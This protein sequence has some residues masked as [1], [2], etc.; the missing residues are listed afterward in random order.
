MTVK[1]SPLLIARL[2]SSSDKA[3]REEAKRHLDELGNNAADQLAEE[4]RILKA[5]FCIPV[6]ASSLLAWLL[7]LLSVVLMRK[8]THWQF[9]AALVSISVCLVPLLVWGISATRRFYSRLGAVALELAKRDDNRAVQYLLHLWKPNAQ[10]GRRNGAVEYELAR[11]LPD[12][13]ANAHFH[14]DETVKVQIRTKL[15]R[16]YPA[17]LQG[18]YMPRCDL[19]EPCIDVVVTLVQ[20]LLRSQDVKDRAVVSR[21]AGSLATTDNQRFVREAA[22]AC[23]NLPFTESRSSPTSSATPVVTT[24]N[25]LAP[26]TITIGQRER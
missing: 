19:S 16:L 8:Q 1:P 10:P 22:R 3:D 9:L 14:L 4:A 13:A 5:S 15:R 20:V 6:S 11:L 24:R 12:L 18:A 7:L 26:Q 17:R 2:L 21:I 23:L 25:T